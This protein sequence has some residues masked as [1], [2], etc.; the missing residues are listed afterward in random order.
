MDKITTKSDSPDKRIN[1]INSWI[2]PLGIPKQTVS[3]FPLNYWFYFET[4]MIK[5]TL[6]WNQKT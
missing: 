6:T 5:R 1:C 2:I 3:K 4:K